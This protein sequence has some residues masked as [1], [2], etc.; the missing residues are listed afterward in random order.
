MSLTNWTSRLELLLAEG[1][2]SRRKPVAFRYHGASA[3]HPADE[4]RLSVST[5][6]VV[7]WHFSAPLL[8]CSSSPLLPC[9]SA[10]LRPLAPSSR[11]RLMPRRELAA[12]RRD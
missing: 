3:A 7:L 9:S 1:R 11:A 4:P 12:C 5:P 2:R 10:R 8:P 6:P